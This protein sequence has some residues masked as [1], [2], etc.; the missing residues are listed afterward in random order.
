MNILLGFATLILVIAFVMI[1][2]LLSGKIL[3]IKNI[4]IGSAYYLMAFIVVSLILFA[5]DKYSV[6]LSYL[7]ISLL[8]MIILIIIILKK[9]KTI[10]ILTKL[11]K[12]NYLPFPLIVILIIGLLFS[13]LKFGVFGMGQ[14]Q[15]VYQLSALLMS[16]GQTNKVIIIKEYDLLIDAVDKELFLNA[17][18]KQE[19]TSAGFY[20]ISQNDNKGTIKP[21]AYPVNSAL[22]HGLPN[23]PALLSITGKIF[24]AEYI[25]Q[26]LTIPY[27]TA[28][29]LIFVT[30]NINLNASIITSSIATS[31]FA[32]SPIVLWTSKAALTEIYLAMI[33][34]LFLYYLTDKNNDSSWLLSIPVLAFSFFHVSIYTVMPMFTI[35]FLGIVMNDRKLGAWVSGAF[36]LVFF[37]IGYIVMCYT[38]PRYTF[39]NYSPLISIFNRLGIRIGNDSSQFSTVFVFI[40][41]MLIVFM[42]QYYIVFYK[43]KKISIQNKYLPGILMCTTILCVVMLIHQWWKIAYSVPTVVNVANAFYGGGL[44]KTLPN[45]SVF[46]CA[47]NTGVVLFAIVLLQIIR[48]DKNLYTNT[49]FPITFMFLYTAIIVNTFLRPT[50]PYYY[51]Y[52]R[53]YVPYLPIIVVL[54][55]I[56]VEKL[57]NTKRA[58]V[59]LFSALIMLPFSITLAVNKDISNMDIKTQREIIE[60][61]KGFESGSIVLVSNN[62]RSFF[63]HEISDSSDCY[64][65]PEY[66]FK[67]FKDTSF[68]ENR[69]MYY[70]QDLS[71]NMV[72]AVKKKE[73]VSQSSKFDYW[74][75]GWGDGPKRLLKPIKTNYPLAVYDIT[76]LQI[77]DDIT[78][79]SMEYDN[80]LLIKNAN[81]LEVH[82]GVGSMWTSMDT[83][84][85]FFFDADEDYY[86]VVNFL[87]PAFP[88]TIEGLN[89]QFNFNSDDSV[90]YSTTVD[91][92]T[93]CI[94][95]AV[96]KELLIGREHTLHMVGDTWKPLEVLG[97]R[98]NRNLGIPITSIEAIPMSTLPEIIYIEMSSDYQHLISSENVLENYFGTDFMWTGSE[99]AFQFQ[100]GADD[101]YRFRVNFLG[102]PFPEVVEEL[103]FYFKLDTDESIIYSVA[104]DRNSSDIE[105]IVP[106]EKL[107][108]RIHTLH[109]FGETW[110][111]SEKLGTDDTRNLGVQITS[112]E[113]TPASKVQE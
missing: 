52:S 107:K 30:L 31:I 46:A 36:S 90:V 16:A 108:G 2:I 81:E 82:G 80:Q 45:L 101:D 94:E 8:T 109:M 88:D 61:V 18:T 5:F 58:A 21:D 95:F 15:G 14:D 74:V 51:Y 48:K 64:I 53:Y 67:N 10:K 93:K 79:L 72:G 54:G 71:M 50:V 38:A 41:I 7:T 104:V 33:I 20:S 96:P 34:S 25:M 4:A 17:V 99:T 98:D 62:L 35:L 105:F 26:G 103:N 63:F 29:V 44:Q 112:V 22:F 100:F 19:L 24:G 106:K 11:E 43:E 85:S 78:Y 89:I 9:Y 73:G 102:Y 28:I 40:L 12:V 76:T 39:D 91:I 87:K 55:G 47:S 3:I 111:P 27:L 110:K 32:V 49:V 69:K 68:A 6:V 42:L 66:L 1:D 13:I 70:I 23:L 86:F 75:T 92:N 97:T 83:E 77:T 59:A 57:S 37:G 60:T 113:A 65:Y 56:S 84:F